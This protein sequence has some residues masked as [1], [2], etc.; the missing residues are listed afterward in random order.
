MLDEQFEDKVLGC[1]LKIHDFAAVSSAYLKMEHFSTDV[2]KNLAKMS[3]DFFKKYGSVLTKDA[4]VYSLKM[5]SDKKIILESERKLY[6]D[7][8]VRL[9]QLDVRD[10]RWVLDRLIQFIKQR[11]IINLIEVSVKDYLPKSNFDEIFKGFSKIAAITDSASVTPSFYK[12]E[13]DERTEKREELSTVKI[14]GIPTG[15][16]ALDEA[17][18]GRGW[19]NGEEY[20]VLGSKK[21]GKSQALGW[22][23]NAAAK[24]G[25]I[26]VYF[27]LEVSESIISSRLDA[28]NAEININDLP[29]AAKDASGKLKEMGMQGDIIIFDYP[30]GQCTVVEIERQIKRLSVEYGIKVDMLVIDYMDLIRHSRKGDEDWKGQQETARELRALAKQYQIPVLTASQINRTGAKKEIA[31]SEDKAGSFGVLAEVDGCITIGAQPKGK[32]NERVIFL[33]DFRNAPSKCI[34]IKTNY[35]MGKFFEEFVGDVLI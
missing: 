27:T 34:R 5:L 2:K 20:I 17:T 16:A 12:N 23:A 14:L 10:Y 21:S 25:N 30:A 22:F 8:Y 4:F 31:Q 6:V 3:I 32:Q 11:E 7:L 18:G 24:C 29:Y 33:S 35:G 15:I 13:I 1:L 26:V 9:I 19:V 28:M